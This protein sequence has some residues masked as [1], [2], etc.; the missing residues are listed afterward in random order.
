MARSAADGT[1]CLARLSR[2][3]PKT[4]SS[5][6]NH[7]QH[8][9]GSGPVG[10]RPPAQRIRPRPIS[11]LG[12]SPSRRPAEPAERRGADYFRLL[13]LDQELEI[14]QAHDQFVWRK[15]ENLHASV[16]KAA[17][18]RTWKH[19]AP[20][21]PWP[22]RRPQCRP[23][24][25]KFPSTENELCVLLGRNPGPIRRTKLP[26]A[27]LPPE[28]PPGLPSALLERRPDVRETEQLL[29]SANAQ[30]GESVAEFFP[31]IGLTALLGKISPELS[32]FTLGGANA[33]GVAAEGDRPAFRGRQVGGTIPASQSGPGGSPAA[34]PANRPDRFREVSDALVSR[35]RLAEIRRQQAREVETLD[36]AVRLS[37]ERYLAGKASYYEVLEAQQQR[38]PA[39]LGLARTQRDERLAVVALYKASGEAG[40]TKPIPTRRGSAALAVLNCFQAGLDCRLYLTAHSRMAFWQWRRLPAWSKI[41]SALDSK[42]ASSISLPR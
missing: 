25:N 1:I 8:V 32:A 24:W 19:P 41:V 34:L 39:E 21:R 40:K 18:P 35:E 14:V 22:M 10:P 17:R 7:A 9:P 29:R 38:F 30:V 11:G 20:K 13:E 12:R 23:S 2:T 15:L 42:V 4:A 36:R 26:L 28:V 16:W 33:W 27:D 5:R 6:G 3:T 37:A 31:K